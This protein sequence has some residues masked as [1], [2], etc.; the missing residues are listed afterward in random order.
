MFV[1]MIYSRALEERKLLQEISRDIVA[2]LSEEKMQLILA[3]MPETVKK[4][5][6]EEHSLEFAFMGVSDEEDIQLLRETRNKFAH[7]ELML[8]ADAGISPMQ[9]LKPD[10]RAA[11]L[12]L[13][14]YGYEQCRKTV[15]EFFGTVLEQRE[16]ND[17]RF[18]LLVQ[19]RNGKIAV[20]FEKIYY[21]EARERKVF[22]RLRGIE[23]CEYETLE[24]ILALLPKGFLRC[25]RSFVFNTAHLEN[26][27]LSEGIAYLDHD[28]MVPVSRSYRK[29]VK[30]FL[31]EQRRI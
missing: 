26:V 3:D 27:R 14:P 17:E 29:A 4:F 7:A 2:H 6:E 13:R 23:Y 16:Q 15:R 1:L 18:F 19:N 25:H 11:S 8:L 12:L 5:L 22:I 28:I 10:V 21:I 30:E 24:H 20:P 9:Y 31:N